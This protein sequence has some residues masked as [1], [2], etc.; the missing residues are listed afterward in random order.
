M[1]GLLAV[2]RVRWI[3]REWTAAEVSGF[4]SSADIAGPAAACLASGVNGADLLV[5]T[6]E[7]LLDDVRLTPFAARKVVA[8]RDDFLR[9][10]Q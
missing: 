8:A 10:R 3:L 4:L 9:V 6:W 1:C 5:L 7:A 2:G